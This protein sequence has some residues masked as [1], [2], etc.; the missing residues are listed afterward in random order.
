MANKR[1]VHI[2][3]TSNVN[4][5]LNKTGNS[6]AKAGNQQVGI[7]GRIKGMF[8]GVAASSKAATGGIRAM[9]VALISSGIGAVVVA[10]GMLVTLFAKAVGES[11]EFE[12]SLSGLKAITRASSEDMVALSD[13]AK[14]LGR[15]TAFTASEVV[16]LQT[17]FAKLGFST[18]DIL[19]V[20]EATLALAAAAGTDLA[21]AAMVAGNTLNGFGLQ[22]SETGRIA[23]VM[24]LSFASSALD[25]EKFQESMKLVA[26]IAKVTKVSLEQSA[27]ALSILADR[28]VAGSLAGTQLRKIMG[29]LSAKTGRNFQ[30]SLTITAERLDNASTTAEKLAIAKELVGDRA[31]G[32]LI[33]LAENREELDQLTIAYQNAGGAADEMAN[34]K[35]DNLRG[36]VTKLSSAWSGFLLGIE[37]GT[38]TLTK[39][40]RG[41]LQ[42]L[43]SVLNNVGTAFD[44]TAFIFSDGFMI[45]KKAGNNS[46]E[47]LKIAFG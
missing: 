5:V 25:I 39:L 41:G 15:T 43:T 46:M 31:K 27:A 2:K 4:S 22:T 16:G 12:K 9:T 32:S 37:D 17:E 30:D 11:A 21:T 29:D 47:F 1:D 35:L 14:E 44:A 7:L 3:V 10:L 6:A 24:A 23:D 42:V 38:G 20:T 36:D 8:N 28:G 33:A 18:N 45:M 13:S 34:E 26:P 19:N 40:I